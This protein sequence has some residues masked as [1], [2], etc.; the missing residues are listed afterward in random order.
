MKFRDER[1]VATIKRW[2]DL[3]DGPVLE[4]AASSVG[5]TFRVER[6]TI[7][8]TWED[9]RWTT[10]KWDIHLIGPFLKAD[11]TPSKA[12]T[13]QTPL[14]YQPGSAGW[15]WLDLAVNILRPSSDVII[16]TGEWEYDA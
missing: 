4:A 3:E 14:T 11:G 9:G 10:D 5:R 6:V 12:D 1:T 13:T 16:P 15:E 2:V 7:V 8:Y